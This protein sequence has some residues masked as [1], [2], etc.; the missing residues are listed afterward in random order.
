MARWMTR[1]S[2]LAQKYGLSVAEY[3]IL[4]RLKTPF[5]VQEFITSIP[6]NFEVD[7]DTCLTVHEVLSQ[8]RA[9]C[10]EAAMVA[11]MAFWLQGR[12]P[13]LLDMR[14]RADD[15]DHVVA[16]YREGK[17][18]GAISKSNHVWLRG[19]DPL[20]RTMRELC[21]SYFHEFTKGREKTLLAYSK[22][23]DL[24]RYDPVLWVSG[25]GSC[26]GLIDALDQSRHYA[27]LS[28]SSVKR[29]QPR[30]S[31]EMRADQLRQFKKPALRKRP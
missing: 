5:Q 3:K 8:R 25:Q 27:L 26:W 19:R 24:R 9:H 30:D 29:L 31:M 18:W 23:F 20:Y 6:A 7:G 4:A 22:P 21:L 16:L 28:K 14:A 11:A 1:I 10:I 17:Y 12:P 2:A 13:L 15:T